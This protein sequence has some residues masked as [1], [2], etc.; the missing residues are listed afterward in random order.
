MFKFEVNPKQ[1]SSDQ[2]D[3]KKN[4][5]VDNSVSQPVRAAAKRAWHQ[6]LEWI[7]DADQ[8]DNM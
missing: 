3:N 2:D 4:V 1:G 5:I 7:T 6:V 8:T